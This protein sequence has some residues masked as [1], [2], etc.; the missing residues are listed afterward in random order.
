MHAFLV[1]AVVIFIA[2]LGDKSQLVAL[3][4]ASRFRAWKVLVAVTLATAVVH[5]L[6][7]AVGVVIGGALPLRWIQLLSG[8]SFLAFAIW[9]L[10]G[11]QVDDEPRI[12]RAGWVV[13]PAIAASFLV[14]ELGDKTMF[15][16]IVLA[17]SEGWFGTWFGSTL[18]MVAADAAAILVGAWLGT[19]LP[20]RAVR[21]G[22]AS[23][24]VVF[25]AISLVQSVR[26]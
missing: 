4:F 15:A 5:L 9:T 1:S 8:L 21:Y 26:G 23:L 16:T 14:S 22:A 2:E 11:D 7:V 12:S 6:S 13:I 10:H 25:G 17:S 18:G 24:F 20:E 19:K 3:T